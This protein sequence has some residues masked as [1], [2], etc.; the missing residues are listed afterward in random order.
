MKEVF[1]FLGV[2][3]SKIAP[4]R[5]QS[6]GAVERFHHTLLQMVRRCT[7]NHRQWDELLPYLLF[8][9]RETPCSTTGFASF[10]LIFGRHVHGPLDILRQSWMPSKKTSL[11]ATEW[12]LQLHQMRQLAVDRTEKKEK[13]SGMMP[14]WLADPLT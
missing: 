6:N 4:Y 11:L 8:A 2:H 14:Q 10:E 5:P 3:H 9:C 1:S 7:Q 12:L 13:K